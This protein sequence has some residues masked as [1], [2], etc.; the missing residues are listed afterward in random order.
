MGSLQRDLQAS[1]H[2]TFIY[3]LKLYKSNE[4]IWMAGP[5]LSLNSLSF[6]LAGV[7]SRIKP[8]RLAEVAIKGKKEV[9]N[10]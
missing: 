8:S 10:V 2:D 3:S 1:S 9:V 6:I 4:R 7:L 5:E